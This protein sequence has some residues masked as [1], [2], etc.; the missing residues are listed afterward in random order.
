MRKMLNRSEENRSED[1]LEEDTSANHKSDTGSEENQSDSLSSKVGSLTNSDEVS[2]STKPQSEPSK[3]H[4]NHAKDKNSSEPEPQKLMHVV[5]DSR[6]LF[7]PGEDGIHQI[8]NKTKRISGS[9]SPSTFKIPKRTQESEGKVLE[10]YTATKSQTIEPQSL[11]K[12]GVPS[13]EKNLIGGYSERPRN[14]ES[15]PVRTSKPP[16]PSS[17]RYTNNLLSS[18]ERTCKPKLSLERPSI[19][20]SK[21]SNPSWIRGGGL[22]PSLMDMMDDCTAN[23]KERNKETEV[24]RGVGEAVGD[25]EKQGFF[26]QEK[27]Q[28]ESIEDKF[29]TYFLRKYKDTDST[30]EKKKN[31]IDQTIR[32]YA[33]RLREKKMNK[34]I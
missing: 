17:T 21:P 15:N 24:K 25:L 26:M 16:T 18:S 1:V 22:A 19:A 2:Q 12:L 13:L 27:L 29:V 34:S 4:I 10:S 9:P 23:L 8:H 33:N 14:L 5:E 20:S 31:E 32:L 28:K 7:A 6:T 3:E 11:V 30:L